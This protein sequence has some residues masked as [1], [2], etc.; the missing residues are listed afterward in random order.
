MEGALSL[1][2]FKKK[3]YSALTRSPFHKKSDSEKI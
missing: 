1:Q 2:A 3:S